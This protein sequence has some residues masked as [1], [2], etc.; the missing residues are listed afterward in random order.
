MTFL[1]FQRGV[2]VWMRKVF[3][4]KTQENQRERAYRFL[5]EAL[6]LFQSLDMEQGEAHE[7]VRYVFGRPKGEPFQEVGG[8]MITLAALCNAT[9]IIM[10]LAGEAELSRVNDPEII[11]K[12]MSKR[13][14][15]AVP[16]D[17]KG[18]PDASDHA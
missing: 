1:D 8:V 18:E 9:D 4:K 15:R 2:R 5:E 17:Y 13:A 7:L 6:E 14:T 10:E 11:A 3:S 16:G 12:I